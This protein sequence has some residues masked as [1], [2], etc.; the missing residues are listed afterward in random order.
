[1]NSLIQRYTDAK[2]MLKRRA[3]YINNLLAGIELPEYLE[4]YTYIGYCGVTLEHLEM[5]VTDAFITL[6]YPHSYED[7]D[8]TWTIEAAWVDIGDE[9]VIRE[10][11]TILLDKVEKERERKIKNLQRDAEY[12]GYE[13]VKKENV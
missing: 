4:D 7:I 12:L 5:D 9:D 13:I 10:Y 3:L 6:I 1:M 8:E 11:K 2:E